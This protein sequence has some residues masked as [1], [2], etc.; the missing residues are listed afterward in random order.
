MLQVTLANLRAH[1]R[2]LLATSAAVL[3]GVAFLV[4]VLV[5]TTSLQA[6]FD[7]LF[8]A[9]SADIDLVVRSDRVIEADD[10]T[11]R[12]RVPASVLDAVRATPGVAA[13]EAD[14]RGTAVILDRDGDEVG[15]PGPPRLGLT[16]I[17]DPD[18]S[19]YRIE[20]GRAPAGPDEVV[21]DV[22]SADAAGLAIGDRTSVL[23]PDPVAVEVVGTATFAGE[24]SQGGV[25][26]ALFSPEGARQH[27]AGGA[28]EV[29]RIVVAAE[30]DA[31]V[32]ALERSIRAELPEGAEVID[33]ATFEA[34]NQD[35]VAGLLNAL[36]PILLSFALIALVVAAFSIYNAFSILVA[37]RTR[38]SAMLRALGATRGQTLRAVL[39]EALIVG[40]GSAALGTVAG[41]GVAAGLRALLGAF[42]LDVGGPLQLGLGTIVVGLGVGTLITVLCALGPAVRASRTAPIAALRDVSVDRTG[43]GRVRSGIGLAMAALGVALIGWGVADTSLARSGLGAGLAIIAVAVLAPA[44]ARP[45]GGVLGAPLRLR[46]V[47]GDLA[48]TN[49][50]RNPRRTAA[51]STALMIGVAVVAL[52]TVFASSLQAGLDRFADESFGGDLVVSAGSG[53]GD[54]DTD[55]AREVAALPEVDAA[56]GLGYAPLDIGGRQIFVSASDLA[57]AGR[58]VDV[59]MVEGDLADVQGPSMAVAEGVARDEGWT[60]GSTVPWRSVAGTSGEV[61]VRGIYDNEEIAGDALM[62]TSFLEDE[63]VDVRD[64]SVIVDL[65]DGVSLDQGRRAL[66]TALDDRAGVVVR[67]R[68]EYL[69]LFAAQVQQ[70]LVLVYGMLALSIVIALIGIANTL[71][72]STIERTHELGLLR[73]VGQSR[74]QTRAM[75]RWES[76]LIAVLGT[77]LGLVAGLGAA[78]ALIASAGPDSLLVFATP[79]GALAVVAVL[80]GLAGV[81]ASLRPAA[82]AAR[83]DPLAAIAAT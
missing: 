28:D 36:R 39:V 51:T 10:E 40:F 70:V 63:G 27:L 4:G 18:L 55:V 33:R 76:V 30:P 65:A 2:R 81:V 80:G 73:A 14:I 72:L 34:E 56:A 61:V 45:V 7:R 16:W 60:I 31:D 83:L 49:A 46:G 21:I 64:G 32:A 78:W 82:R 62:S 58:I 59:G 48:R 29:D 42:D 57:V 47:T 1:K 79:T 43:A 67:D 19:P 53:F 38:E 24:D 9:E 8:R 68:Q 20:S 74:G 71:S 13:A 37:Q 35:Q 69:D 52:F 26:A 75:V 11:F 44:L 41:L 15:T 12:G 25:T 6:G 17:D 54:L 22:A 5:Q 77:V 66:E 23:T 3:L 50:V